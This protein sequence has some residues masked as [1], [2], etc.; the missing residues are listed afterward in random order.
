MNTYFKITIA[1]VSSTVAMLLAVST[2]SADGVSPTATPTATITPTAT[3]T[4]TFT[5]TPTPMVTTTTKCTSEAYGQQ[6]CETITTTTQ[7]EV[8]HK[9]VNYGAGIQENIIM[10]LIALFALSAM[11]FTYTKKN[12]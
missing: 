5:V 6:H 1:I 7:T 3:A 2:V 9:P 8:I 10:A 4:P 12:A 11:T